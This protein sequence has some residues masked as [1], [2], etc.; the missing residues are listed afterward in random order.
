MVP[1][2]ENGFVI[3]SSIEE[4]TIVATKSDPDAEIQIIA[5]DRDNYSSSHKY[6]GIG[7][8]VSENFEMITILKP[9]EG[10]WEI[11]FS[12][13]E[14][15]K[16]YVIT[17]LKLRSDFDQM[18]A[19]FGEHLDIRIWLERDGAKITEEQVLD[20]INV[21]VELT[22][23][24]GNA[25]KLKAFHKGD[26]IFQRTFAPFTPGNH[27]MKLVAEQGNALTDPE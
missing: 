6:S 27:K 7:W 23:P 24:D 1:L 17:N 20:K 14:N 15:N 19:I 21:Y 12:T 25:A 13:G 4:L 26:G 11:L 22:G 9:L 18:Y 10:K 3:D 5:P 2:S 16:A 8:F